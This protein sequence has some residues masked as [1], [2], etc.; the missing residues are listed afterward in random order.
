[1]AKSKTA[2][3]ILTLSLKTQP[4]Q[5]DILAKRFE[6]ARRIY[7]ACLSELLKRYKKLNNDMEYKQV[8]EQPK[9]KERNK[10]LSTY[11]KQYGLSEYSMHDFVKPMQHHFKKNIDAFTAQKLATR[12]WFTFEKLM[13]GNAEKVYF[14]RYNEMDSVE[15][16]SNS[17]GIRFVDNNLVWNGLIISTVIK[18]NDIYAQMAL[19]NRIKF[20]RIQ[21][22]QI[23]GKVKYY[24]QLILEGIPPIK[25][26]KETGEIKQPRGVGIVGLDIG[27][28][29]I[30]IC[31]NTN[32]KLLELAPEIENI[33]KQKRVLQ[34]KL[35]RQRRANNPHKYN[36]DG[37][38]K[39]NR[40]KWIWSK[41]YLKTKMKLAELQRKISDKRKQSHEKLANFILSLGDII[42][43]ET[44]NFKGLQTRTKET[45]INE[46]TGKYN[47]KKRYGKSLANKAPS[48][49]LS[50]I[51]RKLKYQEKELIKIDTFKVKASQYN[52]FTDEYIKKDLSD[53]WNDFGVQ[54]DLYSAFLIMNVENDKIDRN[55]CLEFFNQFKK[56]HDIEIER[57]KNTKTIASM[58]I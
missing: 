30:A 2:S 26:N 42:K 1:M 57:L 40:D 12:A 15:G 54:R 56:L 27:T 21:R 13:F 24:L 51:D 10:L 17:A 37:T 5:E 49:L 38:I 50:I 55:K 33:D 23:R 7:N 20:C 58:G 29:T 22:R 47:K 48:M 32:V 53:R 39:K 43:V 44:M 9:S 6:I 34:R 46:K 45:T 36:P 14:K 18:K 41:N 52:H 35:D 11:Q 8:L 31:S 25:I 16:K 4:Y 3:F 19:Q 28:Q